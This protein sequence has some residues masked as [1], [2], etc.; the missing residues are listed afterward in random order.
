[1][2]AE[3]HNALGITRPVAT[4]PSLYHNRPF[5]VIHGDEIAAQI[6]QAIK[7]E[8][9]RSL[10]PDIGSVNQFLVSVDVLS[11]NNLRQRLRVLYEI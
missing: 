3:M 4:Q 8:R 11:H 2:A 1:M 6:R 5:R 9:V 7:D 10:P